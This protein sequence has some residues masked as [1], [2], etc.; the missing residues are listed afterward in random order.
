MDYPMACRISVFL[1]GS[2]AE[3]HAREESDWDILLVT[4]IEARGSVAYQVD[5]DFL[6]QWGSHRIQQGIYQPTPDQHLWQS[7]LNLLP[8]EAGPDPK[9]D[10]FVAFKSDNIW[11]FRQLVWEGQYG[12]CFDGW[13]NTWPGAMKYLGEISLL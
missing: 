11:Q 1:F 8:A 7:I 9:L 2:R 6:R 13:L 3:G 5:Y 10:L 12:S 4:P